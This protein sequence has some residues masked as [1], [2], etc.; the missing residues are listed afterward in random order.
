MSEKYNEI[1]I[2]RISNAFG[3]HSLPRKVLTDEFKYLDNKIDKNNS[4]NIELN[5]RNKQELSN[6]LIKRLLV[7]IH[8]KSLFCAV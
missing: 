1:R 5:Y 7:I 4:E 8:I 2:N 6:Q 3:N